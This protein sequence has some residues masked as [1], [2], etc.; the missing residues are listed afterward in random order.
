VLVVFSATEFFFHKRQNFSFFRVSSCRQFMKFF[1]ALTL[2]FASLLIAAACFFAY[3]SWI[4]RE[5]E[6]VSVLDVGVYNAAV[7]TWT[8]YLASEGFYG[9]FSITTNVK[10]FLQTG[11]LAV[12]PPPLVSGD[13]YVPYTSLQYSALAVSASVP[14]NVS[15]LSRIEVAVFGNGTLIRRASVPLYRSWAKGQVKRLSGL[16]FQASGLGCFRNGTQFASFE[17]VSLTGVNV[18]V[19][20]NATVVSPLD[21]MLV[22]LKYGSFTAV[23][24]HAP[25]LIITI[26]AGVVLFACICI[27]VFHKRLS[28]LWLFGNV[29][30][31]SHVLSLVAGVLLEDHWS[32]QSFYDF[33]GFAGLMIMVVGAPLALVCSVI[34]WNGLLVH[35]RLS[36][37][38]K[39]AVVW[40]CA[41]F[42]FAVCVYAFFLMLRP[43][44]SPVR[45][46][47]SPSA[48]RFVF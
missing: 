22:A 25:F 6:R 20:V 32:W 17:V 35:P 24:A 43:W 44:R 4:W 34:F 7:A 45:T 2:V 38:S 12:S 42:C 30:L 15:F 27:A 8:D 21:P 10:G 1:F 47:S 28:T 14:F 41:A 16:C 19:A 46:F 23:P 9:N 40:M 29:A 5:A 26:S 39:L 48:V 33:S 37:Q 31:M 36:K 18:S 13:E 3:G 11:L